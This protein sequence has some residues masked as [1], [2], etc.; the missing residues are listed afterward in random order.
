MGCKGKEIFALLLKMS[1]ICDNCTA[2]KNVNVSAQQNRNYFILFYF[3]SNPVIVV[4][5]N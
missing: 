5:F 3:L 2:F 4:L 1:I